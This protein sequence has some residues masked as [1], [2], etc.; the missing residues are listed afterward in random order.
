MKINITILFYIISNSM[1]S[2]MEN[3]IF[4]DS[5]ILENYSTLD[6][7]Y[8]T[9]YNNSVRLA[10]MI[11]KDGFEKHLNNIKTLDEY[12]YDNLIDNITLDSIKHNLLKYRPLA[13]YSN[14]L[15]FD[16]INNIMEYRD[17]K[18]RGKKSK[19]MQYRKDSILKMDSFN[20]ALLKE[21]IKD[22]SYLLCRHCPDLKTSV[23]IHI[24][25]FN[26]FLEINKELVYLM[27][28]NRFHPF[29]YFWIVDRAYFAKYSKP[30]FY[31]CIN[32]KPSDYKGISENEIQMVNMRRKVFGLPKWP[33]YKI[34]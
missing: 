19:D 30:F 15:F 2:Q 5:F 28:H 21:I 3:L 11:Q 14:Q 32:Y 25:N 8:F 27:A 29:T 16:S 9:N 12:D 24:D 17:Q 23:Y 6:Y 7:D 22:T 31:Y 13:L 1:I 20:F 18:F 4:N 26:N 10:E 33:E 34:E